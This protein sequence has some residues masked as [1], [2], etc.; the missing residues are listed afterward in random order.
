MK[1]LLMNFKANNVLMVVI[2][3]L[4]NASEIATSLLSHSPLTP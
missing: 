3:T 4:L 1:K 2:L